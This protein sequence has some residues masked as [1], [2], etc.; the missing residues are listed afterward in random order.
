MVV[1]DKNEFEIALVTY[2]RK[3]FVHE[4]ISINYYEF[5]KRNIKLSVYDSSTNDE[6]KELILN[7]SLD[8]DYYK[9]DSNT[10]IGYKPM[11]P[12]LNTNCKYLWVA[13][14][15]KYFDFDDLDNKVF[16]RV[17][18]SYDTIIISAGPKVCD[19]ETIYNDKSNFLHDCFIS[20]TCIG[21]SIYKMSIFDKVRN[22][23]YFLNILDDKYKNNYGFAWLGYFY[24]SYALSDYNS[25]YIDIEAIPI[26]PKYKKQAWTIRFYECWI[27]NII[28]MMNALPCSYLSKKSIPS[29]VWSNMKLDRIYYCALARIRGGLDY[30]IFTM[31]DSKGYL[32]IVGANKLR[33]KIF[34]LIPRFIVKLIFVVNIL[35]NRLKCFIIKI[36]MNK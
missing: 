33:L 25:I 15:S 30:N 27:E 28:D 16:S 18:E 2:N 26:L 34:S 19:D 24:E 20:S 5:I 36:Y 31:Y 13:G 8:I 32:D 7:L 4:F 17:K 14:D 11:L 12:I 3:D 9:I 1:F 23:K 29:F 6:T 10:N 22:D 21:H 35:I